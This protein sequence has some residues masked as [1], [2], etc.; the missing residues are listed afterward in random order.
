MIE[1]G[2]CAYPAMNSE[3]F[4]MFGA[5][6]Y[7]LLCH[8]LYALISAQ[9]VV[10]CCSGS[11]ELVPR[12]RS[13]RVGMCGEVAPRGTCGSS[14]MPGQGQS[15]HSS[16]VSPSAGAQVLLTYGTPQ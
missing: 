5:S 7:T 10:L 2:H 6:I 4:E 16:P 11:P 13:A 12:H 15:L 9:V 14:R 1:C 3:M 8:I